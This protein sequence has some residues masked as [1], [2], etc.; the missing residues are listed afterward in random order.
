MIYVKR[1]GERERAIARE[2]ELELSFD[3]DMCTIN[4]SFV[5]KLWIRYG[6]SY[7]CCNCH[8]AEICEGYQPRQPRPAR[9]GGAR[10]NNFI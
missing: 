6:F 1:G 7:N 9:D 3:V 10:Q 5:Y 8:P 2:K 4:M